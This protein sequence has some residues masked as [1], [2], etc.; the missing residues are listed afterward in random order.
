MTSNSPFEVAIYVKAHRD[1]LLIVALYVNDLIFMGNNQKL[2]DEFKQVMKLEFKM[3]DLEMMR[4]FLSLEI[5]QGKSGIFV[6]QGA[7]IRKNLLKF[8]MKDS[9]SAATLMELGAKLSK[10]KGGEVMDSNNYRR[11][12]RNLRYM[13]CTRNNIAFSVWV[14]KLVYGGPEI[15]LLENNENIFQICQGDIEPRVV[16][17]KD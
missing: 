14:R 2:I 5:K 3:K 8:G 4:Y 7:Y 17:L 16:L 13:T 1:K 15:T 9:N 12:I 10:P 6:L 11:I